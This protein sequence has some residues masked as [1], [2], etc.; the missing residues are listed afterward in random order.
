MKSL[1][2]V[3]LFVTPWTVVY[4]APLSMRFSRQ[5]Y[6]SGLPFPSPGKIFFLLPLLLFLKFPIC[7]SFV[8]LEYFMSQCRLLVLTL[9]D[10]LWTYSVCSLMSVI[11]FGNSWS[12]LHQIFFCFLFHLLLVFQL[13]LFFHFLKLPHSSWWCSIVLNVFL[14]QIKFWKFLLIHN[15]SHGFLP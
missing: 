2:R 7:F 14:M 13:L 10:V 3:Q 15:H 6:W 4:Q 5:E 9:M 1:S 12:L 11:N 8:Q